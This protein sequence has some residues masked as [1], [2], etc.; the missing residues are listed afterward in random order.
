[1]DSQE[2]F[3]IVEYPA[4]WPQR[5]ALCPS[6]TGP[7]VDTLSEYPDGGNIGRVYLCSNCLRDATRVMGWTSGKR[8]NE[9]SKAAKELDEKDRVLRETQEVA[10]DLVE[11]LK[12]KDLMVKSLESQIETSKN[13]ILTMEHHNQ[14]MKRMA[15][16]VLG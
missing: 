6:Q 12:V 9:L 3:A 1:M 11:Q 16:E 10:Q 8:L 15:S 2:R 4:L 13:K 7:M 5:C 14:E